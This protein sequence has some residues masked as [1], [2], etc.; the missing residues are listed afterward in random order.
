ME[1]DIAFRNNDCYE[2]NVANPTNYNM[3]YQTIKSYSDFDRKGFL[4]GFHFIQRMV[5]LPKKIFNFQAKTLKS[6]KPEQEKCRKF[7]HK[8]CYTIL[9]YF[10]DD[11]P[12]LINY[13]QACEIFL[14]NFLLEKYLTNT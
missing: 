1:Y 12:H 2:S 3:A 6:N 11:L 5:N 7:Y 8:F 4:K 9:D 10:V 13:K 14:T